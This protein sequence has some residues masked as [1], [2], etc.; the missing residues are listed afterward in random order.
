MMSI[1]NFTG[2]I[3]NEFVLKFERSN[4]PAKLHIY[5]LLICHKTLSTRKVSGDSTPSLQ[6]QPQTL[7]QLK[8]QTP[9][10]DI[11]S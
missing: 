9:I 5:L 2:K 3:T 8:S 11:N 1:I 4:R 6:H 7:L 10:T